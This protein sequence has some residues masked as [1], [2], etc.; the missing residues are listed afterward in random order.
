MTVTG[1]KFLQIEGI[2][3]NQ[4]GVVSVKASAVRE[5]E[6]GGMAAPSRNFH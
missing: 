1:G 5:L 3:Q 4:D 2:L 6:F